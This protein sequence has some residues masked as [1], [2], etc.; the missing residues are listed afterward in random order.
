MG[1]RDF[2]NNRNI[3]EANSLPDLVQAID[4]LSDDEVIPYIIMTLSIKIL[5]LKEMVFYEY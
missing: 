5:F 4:P 1:S 3:N 2:L